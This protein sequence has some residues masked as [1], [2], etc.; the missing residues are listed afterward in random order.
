MEKL[1]KGVHGEG[2]KEA[3]RQ[4]REAESKF[5]HS[6][7]GKRKIAEAGN[8]SKEEAEK[9]PEPVLRK[10]SNSPKIKKPSYVCSTWSITGQSCR[11]S[12]QM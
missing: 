10:R 9:P 6:E 8:L 2:N 5:V 12:A 11:T 3:D 7:E 4:F 1:K